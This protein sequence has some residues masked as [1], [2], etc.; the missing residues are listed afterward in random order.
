M[1]SGYAFSTVPPSCLSAVIARRS[2]GNP[3]LATAF[4]ARAGS[5]G[6]R[7][8]MTAERDEG[9]VELWSEEP[10]DT[11]SPR[12]PSPRAGIHAVKHPRG[13]NV[14]WEK[15][16]PTRHA[17]TSRHGLPA[18]FSDRAG[19]DGE[20]SDARNPAP[21]M[22]QPLRMTLCLQML[23]QNEQHTQRHPEEARKGRLEGWAAAETPAIPF[24]QPMKRPGHGAHFSCH[25]NGRWGRRQAAR[26]GVGMAVGEMADAGE[27]MTSLRPHTGR[28]RLWRK[29]P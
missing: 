7:R 4:R 5:P 14:K 28:S 6:L 29:L 13:K 11:I 25:G 10:P 2:P 1:L 19:N 24:R 22:G 17:E 18:S 23:P 8:V 15:N 27:K 26:Y 16:S 21:L 12:H 9:G 3:P 20:R